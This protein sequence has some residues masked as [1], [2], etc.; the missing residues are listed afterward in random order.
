MN[1]GLDQWFKFNKNLSVPM[2]EWN[3]MSVDICRHIAEQN[4]EILSEN[5]THLSDQLKRFSHLKKPE[6]L[7]HLQKECLNEDVNLLMED[8][9]K[10]THQ[11]LENIEE[12]TKLWSSST[13]ESVAAVKTIQKAEREKAKI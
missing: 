5:L 12:F 1:E 2:G 13:H 3:K 4:L 9:Q 8:L 6:D 10:I 11:T 7:L